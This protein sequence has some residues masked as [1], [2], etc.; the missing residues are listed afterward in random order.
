MTA[1]ERSP[2]ELSFW[3]VLYRYLLSIVASLACGG[4]WY[5]V[6]VRLLHLG[7]YPLI[8]SG[9]G[10]LAL[11]FLLMGYLWLALDL[12]GPVPEGIDE[13][14]RSY[15]LFGLWLGIPL[16]TIVVLAVFAGLALV[17]GWI[18]YPSGVHPGH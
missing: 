11:G 1:E 12:S 3:R 4:A 10:A 18:A 15:Q 13:R 14:A 9:V 6:G 7:L 16:A 17:V 2:L 5:E 8:V